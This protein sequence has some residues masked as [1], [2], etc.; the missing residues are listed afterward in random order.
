MMFINVQQLYK[1]VDH[2]KKSQGPS[3]ATWE[4]LERTD[5][6]QQ[7]KSSKALRAGFDV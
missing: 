6:N 3:L 5:P 4:T 1:A 7:N 2:Q